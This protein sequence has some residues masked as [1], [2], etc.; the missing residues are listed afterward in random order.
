MSR[1]SDRPISPGQVAVVVREEEEVG[2]ETESGGED[3]MREEDGSI[4]QKDR[5]NST[6]ELL[7]KRAVEEGRIGGSSRCRV[8]GMR[9]NDAA[10]ADACCEKVLQHNRL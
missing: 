9:Y 7:L 3:V 6:Y 5:P 2:R 10:E 4:L 1:H 8:C